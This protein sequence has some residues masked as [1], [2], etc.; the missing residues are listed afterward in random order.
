MTNTFTIKPDLAPAGKHS[1]RV[2]SVNYGDGY[3]QDTGNGINTDNP[4]WTVNFSN[5]NAAD[6]TTLRAFLTALAPGERFYW[7]PSSPSA[8]QGLY[9]CTEWT[10]TPY[11]N[12]GSA[13]T[14]SCTFVNVVA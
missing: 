11:I 7:T 3:T 10:E 9:K 14:I 1:V 8:V 5:R 13:H 2:L 12:G 4:V 6:F